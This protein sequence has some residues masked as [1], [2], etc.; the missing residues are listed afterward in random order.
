MRSAEALAKGSIVRQNVDRCLEDRGVIEIAALFEQGGVSFKPFENCAAVQRPLVEIGFAQ[1][2]ERGEIALRVFVT[3]E[4][5]ALQVGAGCEPALLA[6]SI[7]E[8]ALL[9]LV[10]DLELEVFRHLRLE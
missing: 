6:V 5:S 3:L 1:D 7:H 2:V 10:Q 8:E 9:D 4:G